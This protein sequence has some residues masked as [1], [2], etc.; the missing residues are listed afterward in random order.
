MNDA[1]LWFAIGMAAVV[2]I[3]AAFA[4]AAMKNTEDRKDDD[5]S[6]TRVKHRLLANPILWLYVLFPVAL[7][8]GV[9][10][11]YALL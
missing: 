11:V 10:L 2:I 7:I 1:S 4:V 3:V 5:V 8:A 6:Q 9:W